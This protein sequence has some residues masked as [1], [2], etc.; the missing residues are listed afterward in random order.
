M[1]FRVAPDEVQAACKSSGNPQVHK[2]NQLQNCMK[3]V[4]VSESF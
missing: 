1:N 3:S 2:F 4:L